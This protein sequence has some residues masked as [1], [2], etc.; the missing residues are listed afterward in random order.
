MRSTTRWSSCRQRPRASATDVAVLVDSPRWPAHGTQFGHLV[1]DTSLD[2]LHAFAHAAGVPPRAFDHD[3]Y[4]VPAA[5]YP[6]LL[7]LGAVQVGSTELLRRLVAAGLRV[8]PAQ[9]TP[10]RAAARVAAESAWPLPETDGL[11]D[12]LLERWVEPQRVYH[13]VRHLAQCLDALRQ[14]QPLPAPRPVVLAV[15]FHDAV[16]QGDPGAD[17]RASA[18]LA[19]QRL[20]GLVPPDEVR[21]VVRL[22]L[23][24]IAHDPAPGDH[25]AALLMDADLSVLGQ[26]RGRY[27][28][29]ARDVREEYTRYDDESY[30][31]GRL[32]V[33]DDLLDRTQLFHTEPGRALWDEAAR[34]NLAEERTRLTG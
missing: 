27:H 16:Y 21:E 5:R 14:L 29:Y 20:A 28:V 32:T 1:Y 26:I 2:E 17:E 13:D 34:R 15:W 33:L 4:D 30:R 31:R 22:V 11:R 19:D 9:R 23:G 3:H 10:R 8:R 24:T 7:A 6:D 25:N 12:E 18:Q